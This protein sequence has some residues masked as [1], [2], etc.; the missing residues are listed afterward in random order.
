MLPPSAPCSHVAISSQSVKAIRLSSEPVPAPAAHV[1]KRAVQ[2]LCNVLR[3][4][5]GFIVIPQAREHIAAQMELGVRKLHTEQ[6]SDHKLTSVQMHAGLAST[7]PP[8]VLVIPTAARTVSRTPNAHVST[9][10][11]FR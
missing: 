4:T 3:P 5:I 9:R 8:M 11:Q 6:H 10:L 1:R 2:A 7:A